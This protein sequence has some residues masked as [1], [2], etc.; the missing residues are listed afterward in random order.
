MKSLILGA[1]ML[2]SISGAA[3]NAYGQ[4]EQQPVPQTPLGA[5]TVVVT[6]LGI[7]PFL[8]GFRATQL[9]DKTMRVSGQALMFY[10]TGKVVEVTPCQYE[11][12]RS[13]SDSR[14]V[15]QINLDQISSR[16]AF[17][18][19]GLVVFGLGKDARAFCHRGFP[20]DDGRCVHDLKVTGHIDTAR[21]LRALEFLRA[22]CPV[23]EDAF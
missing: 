3:Q 12:Y 19:D 13:E 11:F 14:P 5:A 6:A 17:T 15:V 9:D 21:V 4:T 22:S 20:N 7:F 23:Q 2:A 10:T 16:Y 1:I 8:N 18:K